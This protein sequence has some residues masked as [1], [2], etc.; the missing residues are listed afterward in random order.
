MSREM[1]TPKIRL[2]RLREHP[3]LRA[4]VAENHLRVTDLVQPLFIKAGLTEPVPISAMPGV[5]QLGLANVDAEIRL[6]QSL[7]IPA[8]MLF[9]IPEHKDAEGT[10]S[11][12]SDG[13]VQQAI[14]RIKEIAPE[15]L[16]IADVCFCEYTDT[17][18]CGILQKTD[19]GYRMDHDRTALL[20][21]KQS[22]SL[23]KAGADVV[24]P[25]GMI[26]G[27][28]AAIRFGLDE[29]GFQQTPILSYALKYASC[30]YGPFRYASEGVPKFGDRRGHQVDPVNG[31]SALYETILDVEEGADMLMVKPAHAYLD[32]I[33]RVKQQFPHI[34]LGAYQV[35][36]EYSMIK[37][38]AE[39][40]WLDHDKTMMEILLGIKRAGA[41]FIITYFA[42]EA[43][44]LLRA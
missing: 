22:V 20:L 41:D 3:T 17:G 16:V 1:P 44:E 23:V 6:I 8:V 19:T 2:S 24:A 18:H 4:L 32:M 43:A 15:L 11:W 40:S 7:G 39:K 31:N 35:S 30:L 10:S 21:A 29:A 38:A 33:Y 14:R 26:D 13:I 28:V 25:S 34:P 27:M 36:G 12:K 42:K 5:S 9:G 37:A